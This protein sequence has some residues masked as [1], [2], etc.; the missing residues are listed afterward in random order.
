MTTQI[1]ETLC[2]QGAVVAM[3]TE[4]LGD[5]FSLGG[6]RPSFHGTCTALWRGY[7][8]NWEITAGRLYLVGL[9]G[10]LKDGTEATVATVFPEFPE[11]VFAHWYSGTIRIPQGK[12]IEYVHMGYSSTYERDVF[13]DLEHGV[14]QRTRVCHNGAA[15]SATSTQ[16]Q[17]VGAL[18]VIY[19]PTGAD[20]AVE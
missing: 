13:L 12:R 4:P 11:R 17:A 3:C 5:Y 18:T 6:S 20:G 16:G 19:G 2:Y 8:G 10:S 7:V 9:N 15:E 14:V 1:A